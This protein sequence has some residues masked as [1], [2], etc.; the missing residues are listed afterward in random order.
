MAVSPND[1][2]T[3]WH[4]IEFFS[5]YHVPGHK[6]QVTVWQ[7]EL[8]S[9]QDS[10]LPWFSMQAQ[11]Q[12]KMVNVSRYT[13][14]LGIFDLSVVGDICQ[15]KLAHDS[16]ALHDIEARLE[17]EGNSCFV[18]LPLDVQGVPDWNRFSV[19]ALPWA[20][21]C[22][23][24]DALSSLSASQYQQKCKELEELCTRLA[25]HLGHPNS[26]HASVNTEWL[27]QFILALEVWAGIRLVD[28]MP[29]ILEW[30]EQE[31]STKSSKA[32][33]SAQSDNAGEQ[34]DER[35]ED[36]GEEAGIESDMPILNSF[37]FDDL[38]Y[39]RHAFTHNQAGK[40]LQQ[41]LSIESNKAADLYSAVGLTAIQQ[42]VHFTQMPHGRWP[43][44][45]EHNM[46]LM[47]QYAINSAIDELKDGG[48]LS[49]NGPP[50][51]G[52]TT[53]LRDMVAHNVVERAKVLCSF[54]S[55]RDSLTKDGLPDARLAGFEMLVASSNN[56]AVENI[57]RELPLIKSIDQRFAELAYLTP[58]ANQVNAKKSRGKYQSMQ[59]EEQCWGAISAVL[60]RKANRQDFKQ[61][62][63]F[64]YPFEK[65][66]QEEQDRPEQQNFLNMWRWR[67]LIQQSD[68]QPS[69]AAAKR[70]FEQTL[71]K[72]ESVL[73]R[74]AQWEAIKHCSDRSKLP[75]EIAMLYLSQQ[76]AQA[77]LERS[78]QDKAR[79]E[80]DVAQAEQ[81]LELSTQLC[82][83]HRAQRPHWFVR[84]FMRGKS[85]TYRE[86]LTALEH[87][88]SVARTKQAEA[89]Q[90]LTAVAAIVAEK[91]EKE[92]SLATQLADKR[93]QLDELLEEHEVLS[94]AFSDLST[95]EARH[96]ISDPALQRNA[97]W[98]NV[99]INTLRSELFVKAMA[100]HEAWLYEALDQKHFQTKVFE[101]RQLLNSPHK[102]ADPEALWRLFF[103]IVPVASTTFASVGRMLAGVSEEALG[104]LFID[105][106]GQALP[107]Q[108]VGAIMRA[109]RVL[110][111]GDPLQIE[112]VFTTS[113]VLVR[114][115]SE[116]S[117]GQDAKE[118][119]P[120][121]LSVQQVADRANPFG[122]TLEVMEQMRWIGI[123]LWVHRRCVE[124]M[125]SLSNKIAYNNRMIHGLT[126]EKIQPKPAF[127]MANQW[128]ESQGEC[129]DKQHKHQL[130]KDTVRLVARLIK[131]G[132]QLENIYI[133][134]PFK[135]VKTGVI[136]SFK[137][138]REYF[139]DTFAI[140]RK[141][142][143]TWHKNIGTVHIFQGKENEIVIFVLGCDLN[144]NGGAHWA[145]SKPNLLNVAVTRAKKNLFVVGD[146]RV[147]RD[148][149]YFDQLFKCLQAAEVDNTKSRK[150]VIP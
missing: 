64:D 33:Q 35:D 42:R 59:P 50:G 121:N 16:D 61:R 86:R 139:C 53:L 65:D 48:L 97:Y 137:E 26:E 88:Q 84:W 101:L 129:H 150:G 115:L 136:D 9:Q 34:W 92:S 12:H 28:N 130:A 76:E 107:Q 69:F 56:G 103:M 135:A 24:N 127:G 15:R 11:Y 60:G 124:P 39:A 118:W 89:Q 93:S 20:L 73:T 111:V 67:K 122:C 116:Q 98:Q 114:M 1:I 71:A 131:N 109:K 108:A 134:S 46:S 91:G 120:E 148:V 99:E 85:R 119:S 143:Q 36:D 100:L 55:V 132:A 47:Q 105:E 31:P 40:A 17:L 72:L 37:F 90:M 23:E 144:N 58:V 41:Y 8:A 27:K 30:H 66:S 49:V 6:N 38:E 63:F 29:F 82:H 3:S 113:P 123:P 77:A 18:K 79:K 149:P 21:G 52:K 133:I 81:A 54:E 5:P 96:D 128:L 4:L 70:S 22:L 95:P 112:P 74:L 75:Q 19:S 83:E 62:F 146:S 102:V 117:L 68:K 32:A 2:L 106:A 140:P 126:S 110:V 13:L 25:R 87:D 94:R 51:T 43:S 45:P 104:W 44:S 141:D 80:T 125:F 138:V 57:S 78:L 10:V 14:Y 142:Y 147:W 145:G 7:H